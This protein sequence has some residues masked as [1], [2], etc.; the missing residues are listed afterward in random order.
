MS[1][2]AAQGA[3]CVLVASL[4]WATTGAAATLATNTS[5]FAI[6]SAAWGVGGLMLAA[7]AARPMIEQRH[8]LTQQWAVVATS[9]VAV[10]IY[11]LAFYSSMRHAGVAI[12]TVVS[13][14]SAPLAAALIER[15]VDHQPLMRTWGVGAG[16]GVA[17]VVVLGVSGETTPAAG[18]TTSA[19]GVVYG[20]VAG[21]TYA[22]FSWGATRLMRRGLP[23]RPAMGAVFG[24]GGLL[25][26]PVLLT[27]G[28]TLIDSPRTMTV[29]AYLALIPV[30]LGYL[31]FGRG[32]AAVSASTATSLSLLEP[33]LAAMIAMLVLGERLSTHG[34]A[35]L[36][37]LLV[38][39]VIVT[40]AAGMRVS[41]HRH[42]GRSRTG[43]LWP[44]L[45]GLVTNRCTSTARC[46]ARRSEPRERSR[47]VM[48]STFRSR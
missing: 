48:P 19:V 7:A 47:P 32:L 21:L 42:S 35:G 12:G 36:G 39:L 15:I 40:R 33:G 4:V 38:G 29:V 46:M 1:V 20:L 22:V 6:G 11:P 16:A 18:T 26:L 45:R 13:I 41:S 34:Y 2:G 44:G 10:L 9:A 8:R 37:L 43:A 23:F 28:A 5:P 27:T 30:C 3:A 25:L 17:G 14:G 24:L 31:L